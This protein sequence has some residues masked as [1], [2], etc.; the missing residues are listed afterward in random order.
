MRN[1]FALF[2]LVAYSSLSLNAAGFP[3]Q[4]ND[5]S[6][7]D[8][9]WPLVAGLPFP[10]GAL[11]DASTIRVIRNGREVPAQVDVTATWRDGSIRWALAGF[12]GSSQAEYAVE[13]DG[14]T[15]R[16]EHPAPLTVDG[17]DDG[18]LRVSTGSAIYEFAT[19]RLLPERMTM[20][21][22]VVLDQAG[23]GAYLLDNH[24]RTARV[25][26]PEAQ[27]ESEVLKEGPG[28]FVL[29]REGW[30]V[31]DDGEQ[32]A[33][34]RAWFYFTAGSPYLKV[35][36][37]LVLTQDTNDLWIRDYGLEFHTPTGPDEVAFALG[38]PGEQERFTAN[39]TDDELYMLQDTYP[40]FLDEASRAVIGRVA[41]SEAQTLEEGELLAQ[42]EVA[43]DWADGA[44]RDHGLTVVMP[45]LAQQFPKEI[46]FGPAG[47]RVALWSGRSDRELDFRAQTLV[48]EYWQEWANRLVANADSNVVPHINRYWE[49]NREPEG[50][51]ALA[52]WPS[53]AQGS[54]RTHDVWL[55][56]RAQ[57]D[58]DAQTIA[59]RAVAAA[60][61]PLVLAEPAWGTATEAI[62]WPIH[63]KDEQRFADEEA[64]ISEYWQRLMKQFDSLPRTGF[65]AWGSQPY[66]ST[67]KMFRH[68]ILADYSLRRSVWGLYARSGERRYYE[69]GSRFNRHIAD[70]WMHH[71]T[72]GDKFRG[73]FASPGGY[74]EGHMP[75]PWGDRSTLDGD[76]SGHDIHNWLIDYYLTGDEYALHMHTMVGAAHKK[77]WDAER[78]RNV[79]TDALGRDGG[80]A[81]WEAGMPLRVLAS[82]Y[83]REWDEAFGTMA[84]DLSRHLINLDNPNGLTDAISGGALYKWERNIETL[85]NYYKATNNEA[86]RKAVLKALDYH[87]RF[88]HQIGGPFASTNHAAL[89]YTIAYRWTENPDYVRIVNDLVERSVANVSR[90]SSAP[91]SN[92]HPTMGVPA[93]LGLLAKINEP[94]APFPLLEYKPADGS[95]GV[96]VHKAASQPLSMNVALLMS[97]DTQP[98]APSTAIVRA[99]DSGELGEP[100]DE[101]T[102]AVEQLFETTGLRGDPRRRHVQLIVPATAPA[103]RYAIKFPLTI[104]V[105]VLDTTGSNLSLHP[106]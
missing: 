3:L 26:G 8:E 6:G 12:V 99:Y 72:A 34:A 54:A 63:P 82:L 94:I 98:N 93:A 29:R 51:E 37:S 11:E 87:Y 56:P 70:W 81:R 27:I 33:R 38:E 9:P 46:A 88:P 47:V 105:S 1:L 15:S 65:I 76:S 18:T 67:G 2:V 5:V 89:L 80:L 59:A 103:G 71:W 100:L 62:G 35:T 66:L 16:R 28:R 53:N 60:R 49:K 17:G 41:R 91:H 24:G 101:V 50:A 13:F 7:L 95:G 58:A 55:L 30:Y 64:M 44:Y 20:G 106:Q 39:G 104:E 102:V 97:E 40:H 31:T 86:A 83:V 74:W 79:P 14:A 85:Y 68:G 52:A 90:V 84:R 32:L 21:D 48:S 10:E 96:L 75:F 19:H 45:W 61:P 77:H 42:L 23:D 43:G 57:S 92:A 78:V 22:A 73:G 25:A 4:V 36:H 69:Y